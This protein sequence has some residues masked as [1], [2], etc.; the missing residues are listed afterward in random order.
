MPISYLTRIVEFNATHR[1]ERADW[2]ATRNA[3]EFGRAAAAHGHLYQCRVTVRGELVAHAGGV[4]SLVAL[5][6]LLAEVVT[7]PLSGRDLGEAIPEF[8]P[9]QR[10]STGEA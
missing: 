5:D 6:A 1:I 9:G 4:M 7:G 8:G 3:Q 10:L 2:S